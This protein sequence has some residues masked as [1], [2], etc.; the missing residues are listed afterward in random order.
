MKPERW[1]ARAR[2]ALAARGVGKEFADAR[3]EE[4]ARHCAESGQ[5]P[6]EAFGTAEEFAATVEPEEAPE[7]RGDDRS[8]SALMLYGVLAVLG[9][10]WA[11][12]SE[13]LMLPA[14][15]AGLAGTALLVCMIY[16][17]L[18]FLSLSKEGKPRRAPWIL[19]AVVLLVPLAAVAFELLPRKELFPLPAP[20]LIAFGIAL[21]AWGTSRTGG[22]RSK[23]SGQDTEAWLRDLA[24]LLEGRHDLTRERAGEL[25]AEAAAHLT[26]SGRTPEEE[27]G[28]VE[29]YAARLA[30]H[31]APRPPWWRDARILRA[32]RPL[33]WGVLAALNVI[34]GGPWWLSGVISL[35]LC[36][37]IWILASARLNHRGQTAR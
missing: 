16:G 22:T 30:E 8:S 11:W 26:E 20:L 31:E 37:D 5:R 27:F 24:G 1:E 29:E 13:G 35:G 28:P 2:L 17:V 34:D 19:G 18:L 25:A 6:E 4:V 3:M 15:M 36:A 14:T 7:H 32:A 33:G 9:G 23:H 12:I 21:L 10:A